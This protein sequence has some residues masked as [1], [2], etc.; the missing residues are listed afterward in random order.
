MTVELLD[1]VVEDETNLRGYLAEALDGDFDRAQAR[2]DAQRFLQGLSERSFDMGTYDF[3]KLA[4]VDEQVVVNACDALE[5]S[6][7]PR[8]R[9]VHAMPAQAAC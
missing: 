6:L 1:R 3:I 4:E 5:R 8:S 2:S 7:A 9:K